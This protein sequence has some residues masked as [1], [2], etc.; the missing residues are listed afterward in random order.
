MDDIQV[1]NSVE[2][3]GSVASAPEFSHESRGIEF[4]RFPLEVERLSGAVDSIN[5]IVRRDLAETLE[6]GGGSKLYVSG[7]LRSFNNKSGQGSRLVITVFA[8]QL[9]FEDGED[10]NLVTLRGT[11]CKNPSLRTTPLGRDICDM[12]LAVNRRYGRSDYLPCISWGVRAR[13]A[14]A[15]SV[16]TVVRLQGRI[17]SRKYIKTVDGTAVEKTAY[18]VSASELEAV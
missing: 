8:R 1:V 10:M 9:V 7:E 2:L 14:A 12:M 4:Y 16:G 15:W 18:E 3:R 6:V 17:Q 13:D 11:I 5:V